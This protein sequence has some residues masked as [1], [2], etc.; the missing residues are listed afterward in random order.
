[1][2]GGT[3]DDLVDG[4]SGND[5]LYGN[6]GNDVLFGDRGQDYLDGGAGTDRL[7]GGFG[8]DR[9]ALRTLTDTTD[10][11]AGADYIG[12]FS[13]AQGDRLDLRRIDANGGQSGDQ[14][15]TFIGT[16]AFTAA[17]QVRYTYAGD[18]FVELNTDEDTEAEAVIQIEQSGIRE[19]WL[20]L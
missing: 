6:A 20:L 10:T 9:F 2:G 16:D 7:W 4:D 5:E 19:G 11:R 14:A 13:F 17:G 12:D 18:T 15:F 1:V 8:A 3:G